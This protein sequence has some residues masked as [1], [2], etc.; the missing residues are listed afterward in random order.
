MWKAGD[1]EKSE[2]N[3]LTALINDKALLRAKEG[4]EG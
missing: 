3:K 2:W 1:G 4:R